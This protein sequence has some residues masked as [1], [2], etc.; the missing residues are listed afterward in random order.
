MS[1]GERLTKFGDYSHQATMLAR[2]MI[3]LGGENYLAMMNAGLL[4]ATPTIVNVSTSD[5]SM[6]EIASGLTGVVAWRLH[7]K[8]GNDFYY[9]YT[10][11]GAYVTGFG[12]ITNTTSISAIYA[13]RTG[14]DNIDLQLEYWAIS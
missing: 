11:T 12:V 3:K 7:E 2:A 5:A 10:G 14:D 1:T 6:T 9:N 13:Q 4:Q 8:N